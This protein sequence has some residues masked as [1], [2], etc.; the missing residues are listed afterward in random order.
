[1]ALA[2]TSLAPARTVAPRSSSEPAVASALAM[3]FSNVLRACSTLAS[4]MDLIPF[5][6]SKR[7]RS[8]SLMVPLPVV[9]AM[10]HHP[11]ACGAD[12]VGRK[13]QALTPSLPVPSADPMAVAVFG[14]GRSQRGACGRVQHER[15]EEPELRFI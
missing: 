1:M 15:A 9:F 12:D 14:D 4:A 5:G 7:S 8:W 3:N 13:L 11:L 6:I 2:L 10:C